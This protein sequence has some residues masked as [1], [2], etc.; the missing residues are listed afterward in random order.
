MSDRELLEAA[1][2]AF[3]AGEVED[4]SIRWDDA[5]QCILYIHG[6][7]QDHNGRDREFL[8]DPL[9]D[10]RDALR[11]AVK[12]NLWVNVYSPSQSTPQFTNAIVQDPYHDV[13]EEHG[14]DPCAATRRAIVRVAAALATERAAQGAQ[15]DGT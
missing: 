10:D 15:G 3:W 6:D 14:D 12:L 11:L 8:W 9:N 4:M 7:N 13:Y 1:A 5:E 2:Q